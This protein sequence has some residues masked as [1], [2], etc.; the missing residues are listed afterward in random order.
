MRRVLA[1]VGILILTLGSAGC[2]G[3]FLVGAGAAGGYVYSQGQSAGSG[4]KKPSG[5]A[6]SKTPSQPQAP[7]PARAD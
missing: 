7:P 5:E 1:L 2:A 3:L 6:P 4:A